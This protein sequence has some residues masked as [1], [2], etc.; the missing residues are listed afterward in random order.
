MLHARACEAQRCAHGVG[1]RL[2]FPLLGGAGREVARA[3]CIACAR[4]FGFPKCRT[5]A[6]LALL[7][8][9]CALGYQLYYIWGTLKINMVYV[10]WL[11]S[12]VAAHD[13]HLVQSNDLRMPYVSLGLLCSCVVVCGCRAWNQF[14]CSKSMPIACLPP[15]P[16]RG[17]SLSD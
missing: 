9:R 15:L 17:L 12:V 7:V 16:P 14:L 1:I 8:F 5:D 4:R 3:R 13:T 2:P 11:N 10:D 6:I